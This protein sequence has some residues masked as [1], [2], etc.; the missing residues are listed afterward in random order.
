MIN[1]ETKENAPN[2]IKNIF[3]ESINQGYLAFFACII[4]IIVIF[5]YNLPNLN[6]IF[7]IDDS[8][9]YWGKAAIIADKPWNSSMADIPYY[10]FGYSLV[11]LPLFFILKTSE[12]MYKAAILLNI[13]FVIGSY[14]CAS[15][16]ACKIGKRINKNILYLL[17]LV[18]ILT[19]MRYI[20]TQTTLCENYLS[21]LIWLSVVLLFQIEKK[22]KVWLYLLELIVFLMML[23][24]HMRTIPVV[25]IGASILC[26]H[27][28]T[29]KKWFIFGGLIAGIIIILI[30]FHFFQQYH[31]ELVYSYSLASN[32]NKVNA[33]STYEKVLNIIHS[34]QTDLFNSFFSKLF[35]SMIESFFLLPIVVIRGLQIL[36]EKNKTEKVGWTSFAFITSSYLIMI[37][38]TSYQCIGY[39]RNDL[40]IYARYFDF[41]VEPVILFGLCS[42]F[43][44]A[45]RFKYVYGVS[46]VFS[47]VFVKFSLE[48]A[49][50]GVYGFSGITTTLLAGIFEITNKIIHGETFYKFWFAIY[51]TNVYKAANIIVKVYLI[52]FLVF[53][54]IIKNKSKKHLICGLL[55]ILTVSMI[56]GI[57][58]NT[59]YTEIRK[60]YYE[61]TCNIC[62]IIK[63]DEGKVYFVD[64][65]DNGAM[66][67]AEYVQ[68]VLL[69]R[70]VEVVDING[71][72]SIPQGS[73]VLSDLALKN[74]G[75]P[76]INE[77][78]LF[79]YKNNNKD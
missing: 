39:A 32:T 77:M 11:L 27:S 16:V 1:S 30:S 69:D 19:P 35:A 72:K 52:I 53:L 38:L 7:I 67:A 5:L 33:V 49:S 22:C 79:L 46:V 25:L 28:L 76:Y 42:L 10:S 51:D 36:F 31:T 12:Q 78:G 64:Q 44:F 62:D 73:W 74:Y 9:G 47:S 17:S 41:I 4:F 34:G 13:A 60:D 61:K 58:L 63:R 8:F 18:S 55:L 2:K 23:L 66:G 15:F 21:F 24:T 59:K 3:Q 20:Y 54:L 26:I 37:M 29:K 71:A 6:S 14:V 70:E 40:P 68:Y 65:T 57:N 45:D 56:I 50:K 75:K 48:E 43:D